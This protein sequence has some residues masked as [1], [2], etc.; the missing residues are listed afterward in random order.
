MMVLASRNTT[1]VEDKRG[2]KILGVNEQTVTSTCLIVTPPTEEC[3]ML[4]DFD[5]HPGK[6]RRSPRVATMVVRPTS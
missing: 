4:V 5:T 2:L 3:S 1:S 6:G